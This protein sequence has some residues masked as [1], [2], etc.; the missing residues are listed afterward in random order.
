MTSDN[1][2][3]MARYFKE[4]WNEGKLD[5]LDELIAPGYV[6]HNPAFPD[7]P[8]GPEGVKPIMA[9]F[10][11]SFPDLRFVIEDQIEEGDRVVTRFTLRGTQTGDF[12]GIPPTGRR[13]ELSG[14]QIERIVDGKIVE[15]WR[16]SDDLGMLTQLGI[17]GG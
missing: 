6:N 3:L 7:L 12:M 11:A 15:H 17:V 9:G 16:I 8:N 14:I 13:V 2:E 10:R 1:K 4:A 5:I